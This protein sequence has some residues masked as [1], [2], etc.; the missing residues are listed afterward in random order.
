MEN[1]QI[2][3]EDDQLRHNQPATED[4]NESVLDI[5]DDIDLS[6]TEEDTGDIEIPDAQPTRENP[7]PQ[8]TRERAMRNP[9]QNQLVQDQRS[10]TSV[11]GNQ[12]RRTGIRA[13][14][15]KSR[16]EPW[17]LRPSILRSKDLRRP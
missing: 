12:I 13:K 7:A 10:P 4:P 9:V 8:P 14:T 5:G 2:L 3:T 1:F 6:E 15:A 17:K 11:N 16:A